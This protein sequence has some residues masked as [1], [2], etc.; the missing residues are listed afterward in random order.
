MAITSVKHSNRNA[1]IKQN[2]FRFVHIKDVEFRADDEDL[3][4]R[5][6]VPPTSSKFMTDLDGL[7]DPK[8]IN[9]K[10]DQIISEFE[11]IKDFRRLKQTYPEMSEFSL[12]LK[13]HKGSLKMIDSIEKVD[14]LINIPAQNLTQLWDNLF[15]HIITNK[16]SVMRD[17]L[18]QLIQADHFVLEFNKLRRDF[19]EVRFTRDQ[20]KLVEKVASS[21]VMIPPNLFP[22][23]NDL[24]TAPTRNT[25]GDKILAQVLDRDILADEIKQLNNF[26]EEFQK[27]SE[28]YSKENSNAYNTAY[29]QYEQSVQDA[30]E[31]ATKNVD[32][33]TG[34][35]TY[36]GL[37]LPGPFEFTALD[38]FDADFLGANLSSKA[39]TFFNSTFSGKV[40][41]FEEILKNI[42]SRIT[43]KYDELNKIEI[44]TSKTVVFNGSKIEVNYLPSVP[45]VVMKR[46]FDFSDTNRSDIFIT[47]YHPNKEELINEMSIQIDEQVDIDGELVSEEDSLFTFKFSKSEGDFTGDEN[48]IFTGKYGTS[49]NRSYSF[50]KDMFPGVKITFSC[51]IEGFGR[52][53]Y[54]SRHNAWYYQNEQGDWGAIDPKWLSKNCILDGEPGTIDGQLYGVRKAGIAEFKRVEQELCCYVEGEVSHIENILAREY[55]EKS[56]RSLTRS[57]ITTE[58][59]EENESESLSDT[60]ST[61]R[62]EMQQEVAQV[63]EKSKELNYGASTSVQAS[64]GDNLKIGVNA[65]IGGSHSSSSSNSFN[66]SESF[67]KE[68]VERAMER[69]VKKSSYKRTSRMLKEFEE[70]NKHGFDNRKGSKHVTGIYRWVDKIYNNKLVNYGKRLTYEFAIPEPAKMWKKMI[71]SDPTLPEAPK[72]PEPI[73]ISK[74]SS[75]NDFLIAAGKYGVEIE[76]L[77]EETITIGKAFDDS[78]QRPDKEN[79]QYDPGDFWNIKVRT[80]SDKIEI[81][82]DY[83]ATNARLKGRS[84]D[85]DSNILQVYVGTGNVLTQTSL[86]STLNDEIES[87]PIAIYSQLNEK[88]PHKGDRN[89]YSFNIEIDCE[90]TQAAK[91]RWAVQSFTAIMEAYQKKNQEYLDAKVQFDEENLARLNAESAGTTYYGNPLLNRK[92]EQTEL[93]RIAITYLLSQVDDI[94]IGTS[95]W[96][97]TDTC[98]EKPNIVISQQ[99]NDYAEHIKFLEEAIDWKIMAYDFQP[100]FWAS[101]GE[102]EKLLKDTSQSDPI[103]EAFLQAGFANLR[104]P[105]VGG[106]EK[107]MMF[108]LDTGRIW[109]KGDVL[110]D[111]LNGEY[112]SI[113]ASLEINPK[114]FSTCCEDK[115]REL[116]PIESCSNEEEVCIEARWTSRIP[117]TLTIVQDYA[118][119]LSANGLPCFSKTDPRIKYCEDGT[120]LGGLPEDYVDQSA[121]VMVGLENDDVAYSCSIMLSNQ[122]TLLVAANTIVDGIT[123]PEGDNSEAVAQLHEILDTLNDLFADGEANGCNVIPVQ[124]SI[125]AVEAHIADLTE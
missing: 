63:L 88:D 90:L 6:I 50:G 61:D 42:D 112:T 40:D 28:T 51:I 71:A 15:Y 47:L 5:Q 125:D 85:A 39:N 108:F 81:P 16:S 62:Y 49:S 104:V 106:Y 74:D 33:D 76:P 24:A 19:T 109:K 25:K 30:Y 64:Y 23:E 46:N 52:V 59:T 9:T 56:T 13:K 4:H 27:T 36:E 99:L 35:V 37:E 78:S 80:K 43:S 7:E 96:N 20:K 14:T 113:D 77:K 98:Q 70:N 29:R 65:N 26:R 58:E 44:I 22:K 123:D 68:V 1:E 17:K 69:V 18:L 111:D 79:K 12:W 117:T 21:R 75:L 116:V 95:Y 122:A 91:D 34:D 83:K 73:S 31:A 32:P 93:K 89:L 107:A 101:C 60:T 67:A 57:E 66:N 11:P 55:K 124:Q 115:G 38:M 94:T 3:I 82:E 54:D 110:V 72:A 45:K 2:L 118:A 120:P 41:S 10:I 100:Y 48:T 114:S 105:V 53:Y 87:V 102:W 92:T 121:G 119:P 103:F 84:Y 8:Q 86:S 97:H